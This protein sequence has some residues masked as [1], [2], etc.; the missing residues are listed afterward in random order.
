MAK[1]KSYLFIGGPIDGQWRMLDDEWERIDIVVDSVEPCSATSQP[2]VARVTEVARYYK[3]PLFLDEDRG[4]DRFIF[5]YE[6]MTVPQIID[7]LLVN[8]QRRQGEDEQ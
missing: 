4:N 8:Y 7:S 6:Y 1:S 3:I 5:S 2:V